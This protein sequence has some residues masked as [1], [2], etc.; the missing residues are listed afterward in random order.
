MSA[1]PEDRGHRYR[2]AGEVG[3]TATVQVRQDGSAR[4][5]LRIGHGPWVVL[6]S[7]VGHPLPWVAASFELY[8]EE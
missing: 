8:G 1:E 5:W 4:W 2:I 6:R 3:T 7:S